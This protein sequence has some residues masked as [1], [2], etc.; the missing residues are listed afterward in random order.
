VWKPF[1][2]P[3]LD[4]RGQPLEVPLPKRTELAWLALIVKNK[5]PQFKTMLVD[6]RTSLTEDNLVLALLCDYFRSLNVTIVEM[7]SGADLTAER[8]LAQILET[9]EEKEVRQAREQVRQ[10]KVLITRLKHGSPPGRKRFGSHP[11][12][13][14]EAVV[15]KRLRALNRVLPVNQWKI[16]KGVLETRRSL[17]KIAKIMNSEGYR[18]QTGRLWSARAVSRTLGWTWS[19]CSRQDAIAK[20]LL[21]DVSAA[22][23]NVGISCPVAITRKV[24]NIYIVPFDDDKNSGQTIENRLDRLLV[25]YQ[26]STA[27]RTPKD[28]TWLFTPRRTGF[29]KKPTTLRCVVRGLGDTREP[30]VTI[31]FSFEKSP[32]SIGIIGPP[33]RPN[34]TLGGFSEGSQ[35][36]AGDRPPSSPSTP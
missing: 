32:L 8:S 6:K 24:W 22:A 21:E 13:L 29:D 30:V 16:L 3:K 1:F 19:R 4:S 27:G 17:H 35:D 15:L 36:H 25:A 23:T 33:S 9:A 34:T 5:F 26:K 20:H 18:T 11:E 14:E 2:D 7:E 28:I 12:R 31:M 10:W